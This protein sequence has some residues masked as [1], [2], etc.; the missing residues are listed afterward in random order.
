MSNST[1]I[2]RMMDYIGNT[3]ERSLYSRRRPYAWLPRPLVDAI[4]AWKLSALWKWK[5]WRNRRDPEYLYRYAS[6]PK[7]DRKSKAWS[8]SFGVVPPVPA[9]WL[10][11]NPEYDVTALEKLF[12]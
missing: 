1:E 3:I 10:E 4:E 5:I 6:W 12:K 9:Q 11:C 8:I 7:Y 2:Q